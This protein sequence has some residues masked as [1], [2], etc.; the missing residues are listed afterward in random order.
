MNEGQS[1]I[2]ILKWKGEQQHPT[3]TLQQ[4]RWIVENNSG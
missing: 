3:K 1:S 2:T 4:P